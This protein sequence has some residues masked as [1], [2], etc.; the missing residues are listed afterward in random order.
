MSPEQEP[1]T[2]LRIGSEKTSRPERIIIRR[3]ACFISG[4]G[5]LLFFLVTE[6]ST[7]AAAMTAN[8]SDEDLQ[9]FVPGFAVSS[10]SG[11]SEDDSS[12][13]ADDSGAASDVSAT[14]YSAPAGAE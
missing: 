5:F 3:A 11:A 2:G 12:A 4:Q 6:G 8:A 1:M 14:V 7:A 9:P 10:V 13:G